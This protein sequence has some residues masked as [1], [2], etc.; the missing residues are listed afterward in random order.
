MKKSILC[1]MLIALIFTQGCCSIFKADPQTVSV[2]SEPPGAKVT[3]G[4]HQGTTP[5][6]VTLPKGEDYVI[7]AKYGGETKTANLNK[8]IEPL[9][10][11]NILFWP[12]LII[13]LATGKM[14]KYNPTEY[15]FDFGG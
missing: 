8:D 13:D 5:Y 4:P 1:L 10:W 15:S 7:T 2:D 6:K 3:I 11:V 9:Y 14:F 12:G